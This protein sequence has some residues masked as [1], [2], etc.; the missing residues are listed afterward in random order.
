MSDSSEH[1]PYERDKDGKK[2][3]CW[4]RVSEYEMLMV[5][6]LNFVRSQMVPELPVLN[7]KTI[8][9]DWEEWSRLFLLKYG[10]IFK[11][12]SFQ[13]LLL[14]KLP[15]E[16][17]CAVKMELPKREELVTNQSFVEFVK[18]ILFRVYDVRNKAVAALK[19]W[20]INLGEGIYTQLFGL[21][22]LVKIAF[23][24]ASEEQQQDIM[25]VH[26]L[27]WA[28]ESLPVMVAFKVRQ[29]SDYD[30][31]KNLLVTYV[32]LENEKMSL[33]RELIACTPETAKKVFSGK[34]SKCFELGHKRKECAKVEKSSRKVNSNSRVLQHNVLLSEPGGNALTD[35][36]NE[37]SEHEHYSAVIGQIQIT[38]GIESPKLTKKQ[39]ACKVPVERERVAYSHTNPRTNWK[40]RAGRSRVTVTPYALQ[41]SKM[42]DNSEN[43]LNSLRGDRHPTGPGKEAKLTLVLVENIADDEDDLKN[44]RN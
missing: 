34:C 5:E 3:F 42:I 20:Q 31:V 23:P 2:N 37:L 9:D 43:K 10:D 11:T 13:L 29:C 21:E 12:E 44:R 6:T 39:R 15:E 19:M 35:T 32:S 33:Q 4:K 22:K 27:S 17:K 28:Q 38:E 24:G 40:T 41:F 16:L 36:K 25:K 7:E 8:T 18:D 26:L 1:S 14:S 30:Q